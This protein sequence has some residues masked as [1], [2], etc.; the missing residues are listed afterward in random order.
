MPSTYLMQDIIFCHPECDLGV[1]LQTFKNIAAVVLEIVA[2]SFGWY[3][4]F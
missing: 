4:L 2:P 3:I 1:Y